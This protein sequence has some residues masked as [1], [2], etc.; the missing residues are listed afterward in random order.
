MAT[1]RTAAP[2]ETDYVNPLENPERANAEINAL[3]SDVK[4]EAPIIDFPPDD[5]VNLPGGLVKKDKVITTVIVKELNGLD[6]EVLARAS[7]SMNP[8]SFI[9]RLLKQGVVQIGDEP[10]S[11]T[12]RLLG[13]LL[14]GDREALILGIR[15]VTYGENLDIENWKCMV[16]GTE[17]T[18]SMQ[19][20]DIPVEIM[21]DPEEDST[22]KVDLRKGGYALVRLATGDDQLAILDKG[23]TDINMAQQQTK[24]LQRCVITLVDKTG[25]ERT[26]QG[27]PSLI[28]EM[29][30]PDRHAILKE[31]QKRQPGPKYDQVKYTCESCGED[32]TVSVG[33][34]D[35]FLDI[36]WV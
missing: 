28:L 22:F 15:R 6:E 21:K 18:L 30:M 33:I 34:G 19:L 26:V 20:S 7:Q 16:C 10:K 11:Q 9:D 14:I 36:G 35:L 1:R 32:T 5:L 25:T 4:T 13:Q 23:K 31:L 17:A 12:E 3:L 2:A 24:L 27:F 8:Y 29:S